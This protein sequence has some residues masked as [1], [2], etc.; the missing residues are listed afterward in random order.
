MDVTSIDI[1]NNVKID[2]LYDGKTWIHGKTNENIK[3]TIFLVTIQGEQLKYSLDAINNLK[4]DIPVIVNVI[5]NVCPTN[6]AYNEMRLRCSTDYFIQN[7]EDMELHDNII[8]NMY[9]KIK[10]NKKNKKNIFLYTYKLIDNVL[11]IGNPPV[12]DCLKLYNN[13]IM[14]NYPTFKNGDE[15]VASVDSLWHK[16]IQSNGYTITNTKEIA[17]YHGNNR[18][19]FDLLL[20]Y[21]KIIKSIID[22]RIKTNSGHI[23]KIVKAISNGKGDPENYLKYII[24]VFRMENNINEEKFNNIINKLNTFITKA[25]LKMYNINKRYL[26][27]KYNFYENNI[28]NDENKKKQD[29]EITVE[30][31]NKFYG[32]VAIL[33]IATDNYGYSKDKYPYKYYEYFE[34]KSIV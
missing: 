10:K 34:K 9:N 3:I 13:E 32:L 5:M 25:S 17:G 19:N 15:D 18:T 33:C 11:G 28:K 23:C 30:N 31:Y 6:K 26:P 24:N 16:P 29:T 2:E 22:P 14:K 20:R 4:I 12:I 21:C 8:D 1:N 7:D 27:E